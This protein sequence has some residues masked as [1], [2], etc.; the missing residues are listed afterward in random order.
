MRSPDFGIVAGLAV[1]VLLCASLPYMSI[2]KRE[3]FAILLFSH[4]ALNPEPLKA[5]YHSHYIKHYSFFKFTAGSKD[6]SQQSHNHSLYKKSAVFWTTD[7][8]IKF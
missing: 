7:I 8:D 3:L 5:Q 1:F 2:Y 4:V 6:A